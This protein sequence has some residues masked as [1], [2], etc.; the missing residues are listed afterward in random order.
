MVPRGRRGWRLAMA[1]AAAPG[2]STASVQNCQSGGAEGQED[3]GSHPCVGTQPAGGG[4]QPGGSLNTTDIVNQQF[5]EGSRGR[6][7]AYRTLPSPAQA[8][9]HFGQNA[10]WITVGSATFRPLPRRSKPG[11]LKH[12]F[13][14]SEVRIAAC[15]GG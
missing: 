11:A 5:F 15:R 13:A 12:D 4:G 3:S 2:T 8:S 6:P 10:T 14:G 1:V 7:P 9:A